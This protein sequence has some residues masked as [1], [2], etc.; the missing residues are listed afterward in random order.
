MEKPVK[1]SQLAT[2]LMKSRD[3]YARDAIEKE[4]RANPSK[5]AIRVDA[6]G[7]YFVT[8]VANHRYSVV[9]TEEPEWVVVQAVVPAQFSP[10]KSGKLLDQVQRAVEHESNG[11]YKFDYDF[12]SVMK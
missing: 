1:F 9:W 4:F 7:R 6:D 12:G 10:H 8:P 2:M 11:H 5:D 3:H